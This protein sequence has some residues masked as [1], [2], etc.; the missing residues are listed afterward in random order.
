MKRGKSFDSRGLSAVVTTLII[1]LLVIVAIGIVW[2]VI[3]NVVDTGTEQVELSSK[4]LAVDIE[5]VSVVAN[6]SVAN[7]YDVTLRRKAGGDEIGGIGVNF[8]NADSSS[9]LIDFPAIEPLNTITAFSLVAGFADANKI[10]YTAYFIDASGNKQ[11]C[12]QT[13]TFEF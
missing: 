11:Y 5:A 6:A 12:S 10:E 7:S 13:N 4:C 1:I 2:V 8:F 9:G 3:R